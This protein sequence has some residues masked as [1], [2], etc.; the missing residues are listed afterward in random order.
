MPLTHLIDTY[1]ASWSA[2]NAQQ[3]RAL[4]LSI[5][6]DGATYTDPTVHAIGADE[7]LAH[8]AGIQSKYPG[9]RI[10][11][12]SNVD[13]HHDVA[14]FAWKFVMPDGSFSPD[15]I[16]IAFVDTKQNRLSRIIGFFGVLQPA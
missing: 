7:L 16:D 12:T 11:R 15:G 2:T 8:I 10:E 3:R 13:V 4:L 5:W 9:A 1:C 6:N 14:R